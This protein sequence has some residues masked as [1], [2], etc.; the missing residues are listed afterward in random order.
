MCRF[1]HSVK[2]SGVKR[3]AVNLPLALPLGVAVLMVGGPGGCV[4]MTSTGSAG[5]GGGRV[6]APDA[7]AAGS[8][9][10]TRQRALSALHP[11]AG[12]TSADD[13]RHALGPP[14]YT[15]DDQAFFGYLLEHF[16]DPGG[17]EIYDGQK[18]KGATYSE[19]SRALLVMQ[20]GPDGVLRRYKSRWIPE[21]AVPSERFMQMAGRWGGQATVE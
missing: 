17:L 11:R 2:I 5:F 4:R 14:D 10:A 19:V 7:I 6:T 21:D 3:V 18:P 1:L 15:S 13:V 20:F 16:R 9:D 8:R 12:H